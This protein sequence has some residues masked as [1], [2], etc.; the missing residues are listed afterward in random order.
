MGKSRSRSRDFH[1]N[2]EVID[3]GNRPEKNAGEPEPKKQRE[4]TRRARKRRRSAR[5]QRRKD[6]C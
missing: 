2:N 1:R 4:F 3:F 5:R 6:A